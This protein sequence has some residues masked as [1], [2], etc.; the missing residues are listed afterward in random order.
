MCPR[1]M[2]PRPKVLGPLNNASLTHVSRLWTAYTGGYNHNPSYAQK[3]GLL[4]V[5]AG[6]PVRCVQKKVHDEGVR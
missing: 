5:P 2:C 1:P 4:R 6:H 3:L